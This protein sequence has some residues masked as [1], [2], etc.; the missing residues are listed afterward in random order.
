MSIGT[1]VRHLWD[2]R[3]RVWFWAVLAMIVAANLFLILWIPWPATKTSYIGLLPI[4][5]AHFFL[6]RGAFAI[7]ERILR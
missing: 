7:A 2:L 4:G 6:V 1:V 3:A 5:L